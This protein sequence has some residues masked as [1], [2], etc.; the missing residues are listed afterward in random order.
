MADV[1][2]PADKSYDN[3]APEG[4]SPQMRSYRKSR[5][6]KWVVAVRHESA[7]RSLRAV[8]ML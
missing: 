3:C 2:S 6:W 5:V 1:E 8:V 4:I 7:A